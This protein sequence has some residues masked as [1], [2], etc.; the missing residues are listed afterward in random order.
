MLVVG[1]APTQGQDPSARA[2]DRAVEVRASYGLPTERSRV[3][4]LMTALDSESSEL[5]SEASEQYGFPLTRKEHDDLT[6]RS[7]YARE[8]QAKTLP[9]VEN[10]DGYGGVWLDHRR[11]GAMVVGLMKVTAQAKRQ[12]RAHLPQ[13]HRGIRF[14]TVNHSAAE[15]GRALERAEHDWAALG[16][17]LRPQAFAISYRDNRLVVKVL[18]RDVAKAERFVAGMVR[19]AGVDVAIEP[20]TRVTDSA[21][22]TRQKCYG[23][24]RLGA[25]I[26]YPTVYDWRAPRSQWNCAI[27]F[28]LSNRTILTAG[29]CTHRRKGPWH[30]HATYRSRYGPIGSQTSSRYTSKHRDVSL[31]K[32]DDWRA[33]RTTRIFGDVWPTIL[34]RPGRV[35]DNMDVCVSLARQDTFWCGRVTEP[36]ARWWSS[37]AGIWVWGAGMRFNAP[38]RTSLPGD[39][40]SPVVST[41]R[42]C[43]TCKPRRTPIGIVNSGNEVDGRATDPRTGKPINSDLYFA[44]VAW[45]LESRG[46]WPRLEIYRGPKPTPTPKPT[47]KPTPRP[48]PTPTP[49]PTPTPPPSQPPPTDPPPSEAP[50]SAPPA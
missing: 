46:G 45:A 26:N 42:K 17:G 39:S 49:K 13:H 44:K 32:L 29:H 23:P 43:A 34:T 28:M 40:G 11:G 41:S 48:T 24:L 21:C 8:F 6:A 47:P 50:P 27:G 9:F 25:R 10:L 30:G 22:P 4:K 2:V 36:V 3:R 16:T 5:D 37:T 15:L 38:G 12:V 19:R 14:V 20:S 7:T 35:L 31:I 1:T 33:N 18:A